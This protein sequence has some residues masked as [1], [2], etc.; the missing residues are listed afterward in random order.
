MKFSAQSDAKSNAIEWRSASNK[1]ALQ[2]TNRISDALVFAL[3]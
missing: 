1:L 3:S 2:F